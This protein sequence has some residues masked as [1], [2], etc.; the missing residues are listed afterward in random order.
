[1]AG[2]V[3]SV[4]K[5]REWSKDQFNSLIGSIWQ[6]TKLQV[7][8]NPESDMYENG[9]PRL[10]RSHSINMIAYDLIE[11]MPCIGDC[12]ILSSVNNYYRPEFDKEYIC[13]A[14]FIKMVDNPDRTCLLWEFSITR[15]GIVSHY[16]E[17]NLMD[18]LEVKIHKSI[19]S[20]VQKCLAPRMLRCFQ[21]YSTAVI[22]SLQSIHPD[23]IKLILDYT[24]IERI[25]NITIEYDNPLPGKRARL[26]Y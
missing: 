4:D 17:S 11:T 21:E 6:F 13:C 15:M 14:Q 16:R 1:M 23:I 3:F 25:F 7:S 10:K 19:N 20:D 5:M 2:T 8:K 12:Y 9:I 24:P 18:I 22:E 26:G